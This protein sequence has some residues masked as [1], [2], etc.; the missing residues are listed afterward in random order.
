MY[1][2]F[3]SEY[4]KGKHF[5]VLG[6]EEMVIIN[7]MLKKYVIGMSTSCNGFTTVTNTG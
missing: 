5:K 2:K 4:P 3:L 1:T 6:V 7:F